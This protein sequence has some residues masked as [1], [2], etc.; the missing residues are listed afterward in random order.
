MSISSA[1]KPRSVILTR[2]GRH[3]SIEP[4][5]LDLAV[6]R[7]THGP[8]VGL[9]APVSLSLQEA[10]WEVTFGGGS[11][12]IALEEPELS[13]LS[14]RKCDT[15]LLTALPTIAEGLIC[16][17]RG[18]IDVAGIVAQVYYAFPRARIGVI[19]EST[20]RRRQLVR[21]LGELGITAPSVDTRRPLRT[22][23]RL[24]VSS[25]YGLADDEMQAHCLDM[26]LVLDATQAVSERGQLALSMTGARFRLF[27][28]LPRDAK[29]APSTLYTLRAT[30]GF[31]EL[32]LPEHGQVERP[33]RVAWIPLTA[34]RESPQMTTLEWKRNCVWT[35]PRR[36]RLVARLA[37]GVA[38][39]DKVYL[40]SRSP[41]LPSAIDEYPTQRSIL[42]TES[43][44]QA[45]ALAER[46]PKWPII[47]GAGEESVLAERDAM[48]V[49]QRQTPKASPACAIVTIDGMTDLDLNSTAVVLW[50]GAGPL[51][52]L[53]QRGQLVVPCGEARP[54][55]IIDFSDRSGPRAR[56]WTRR[57]RDAY[58]DARWTD[59]GRHPLVQPVEQFLKQFGQKRR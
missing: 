59:F 55:L 1:K 22:A 15:L 38:D 12:V 21:R 13:A 24:V 43:I 19:E 7:A 44:R 51:V 10:G 56:K 48:L 27:G 49:K 8:N 29:L 31:E 18:R 45:A 4:E 28:L 52:P 9:M 47:A 11:G 40:G 6:N 41:K 42:L 32:D 36:N 35:A 14:S 17:D 20:A 33:V 53:L 54:L 50:C 39:R 16:Y 46:L 37:K 57:R 58:L 23:R 3:L 26:V 30:F 2:C 5:K 34:E 25:W